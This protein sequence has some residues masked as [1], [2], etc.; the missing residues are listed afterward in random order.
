MNRQG[1][2]HDEL[3]QVIA[4]LETLQQ[5]LQPPSEGPAG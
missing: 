1:Q 4:D 2:L 5:G 3:E